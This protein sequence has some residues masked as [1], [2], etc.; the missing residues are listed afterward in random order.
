MLTSDKWIFERTQ[1]D[2]S[3]WRKLRIE[4]NFGQLDKYFHEKSLFSSYLTASWVLYRILG[5]ICGSVYF[6]PI[7]HFI[8]INEKYEK[9]RFYCYAFQFKSLKF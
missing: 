2:N 4:L 6:Y 5:I 7:F 9:N 1:G 3:Y 8:F